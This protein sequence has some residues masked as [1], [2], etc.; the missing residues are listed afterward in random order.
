MQCAAVRNNG[1]IP[2]VTGKVWVKALHCYE[3][4]IAT[5]LRYFHVIT[6]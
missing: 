3:T 1:T 2:Y 5:L 4:H 6:S